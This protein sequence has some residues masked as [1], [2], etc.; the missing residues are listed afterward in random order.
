MNKN[1]IVFILV[2]PNF[3]GNIGSTAR[4]MKNF[5][6]SQL[7]LVNPPRNYL[8]AEARKMAVDAFDVLKG[9]RVENSLSNALRDVNLAFSTSACQHRT[10]EPESL[11]LLVEKIHQQDLTSE[12]KVA[13]VFGDER[14]GLTK[15]EIARCHE[16]ILV[17]TEP[18]FASL[19]LAQALG[20]V[21]YELSRHAGLLSCKS[22]GSELLPC[23]AEEDELM[24]LTSELMDKANFSRRYNRDLVALQLRNALQKMRLNKREFDLLRGFL[25]RLNDKLNKIEN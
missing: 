17:P 7:R 19:N 13:F 20:I 3:L 15:E 9:A 22:T 24:Q 18:T 8:D 4:V 11:G 10:E 5:G 23:G 2:R 1:N 16:L 21:A 25:L 12:N 6:F 14:D